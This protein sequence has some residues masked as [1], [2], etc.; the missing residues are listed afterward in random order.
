[1]ADRISFIHLPRTGGS[2]IGYA[3]KEHKL[4][5]VDC[6]E[7]HKTARQYHNSNN[8]F[9]IGAIRNP[10]DWYVSR[11]EYFRSARDRI[12]GGISKHNDLGLDRQDFSKKVTSL[13]K[14]LMYGE[15]CGL[16]GNLPRFWLSDMYKYC[17][18]NSDGKLLLDY[19]YKLEDIDAEYRHIFA[20]NNLP[21]VENISQF[22]SFRNA[23]IRKPY[24]H[25]Q[26]YDQELKDL[27]YEKDAFIF[28]EYNYSF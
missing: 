18:C 2:F 25:P 6:V 12:E 4:P 24:T 3:T 23:S 28:E 1:M 22:D 9:L 10:F 16:T 11:F 21:I 27:I 14:H 8:N 13:K 20:I 26:Y 15:Y 7:A 17:F 5:Y 19:V